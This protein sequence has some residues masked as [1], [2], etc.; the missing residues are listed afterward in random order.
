[1]G[2]GKVG[3]RLASGGIAASAQMLR[4][5]RLRASE[6]AMEN[7]GTEGDD[8]L[9]SFCACFYLAEHWGLCD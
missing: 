3:G 6:L 9:R 7:Y 8:A 1:M 4:S 5:G 2:C